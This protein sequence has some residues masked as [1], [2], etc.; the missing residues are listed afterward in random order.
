MTRLGPS[1]LLDASPCCQQLLHASA[2]ACPAVG[3]SMLLP[4]FSMGSPT[5]AER[6]PAQIYRVGYG[7]WMTPLHSVLLSERMTRYGALM[8][9]NTG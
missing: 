6:G 1:S 2:S 8:P 7:R 4:S 5:S 3:P 9:C